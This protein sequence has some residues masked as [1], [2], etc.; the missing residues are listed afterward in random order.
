MT[1]RIRAFARLETALAVALMAAPAI[2]WAIDGGG[3]RP[4]IS[5]YHDIGWPPAFYGPLYIAATLLIVNGTIWRG[6]RYNT[7]LG[8]ALATLTS[9]DHDAHSAAHFAATAVFFAGAMTTVLVF[10]EGPSRRIKAVAA[11]VMA[12]AVAGVAVGAVSVYAGEWAAMIA[13][14]AHYIADIDPKVGYSA[15]PRSHSSASSAR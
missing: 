10:S 2:M 12:G 11:V 1:A 3:P 6:H 8:L 14:A 4:S 9:F 15:R 5:A 7:V 13:I